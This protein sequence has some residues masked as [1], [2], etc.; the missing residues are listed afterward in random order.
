MTVRIVAAR[1][2]VVFHSLLLFAQGTIFKP[3]LQV[4]QYSN[5]L[6]QYRTV[7]LMCSVAKQQNTTG[8]PVDE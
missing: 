3:V 8:L 1:R 4:E 6:E 5:E 7:G 2:L